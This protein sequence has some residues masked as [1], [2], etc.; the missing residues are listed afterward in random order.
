M[1]TLGGQ[2]LAVRIH[3]DRAAFYNCRFLGY[4]DTLLDDAGHHFFK[5]CFIEG[6]VDFIFGRGKSL[7]VNCIINVLGDDQMTVITAQNRE[8]P[9]EDAGF[10][11]VHC[12]VTGTGSGTY[13]GRA[14]MPSPKTV[15]SYTEIGAHI[16]PGG[17]FNNLRPEREK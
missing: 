4:Q 7:Y 17:W 16:T 6:T 9:T 2:A 3:G 8:K 13:L 15:F 12:K 5:D 11:F 10:S 14:W 1:K